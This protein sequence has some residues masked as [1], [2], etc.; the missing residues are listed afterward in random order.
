[1]RITFQTLRVLDFF[2]TNPK[3]EFYGLELVKGIPE[4]AGTLYPI[5]HRLEKNGW[6]ESYLEG[7]NP[8][9]VERGERKY[10]RLTPLGIEQSKFLNESI[11]FLKLAT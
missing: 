11:K 10:Y 1:M 4:K 2:L 5:L 8:K 6:L 9:V 3:I 7:V